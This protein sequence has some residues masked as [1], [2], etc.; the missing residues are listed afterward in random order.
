MQQAILDDAGRSENRAWAFGYVSIVLLH[1]DASSTETGARAGSMFGCTE[2]H[3][4]T[5]P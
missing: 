1:F 5:N 2:H 4:I 3:L